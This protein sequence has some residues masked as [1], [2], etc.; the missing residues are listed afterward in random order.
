MGTRAVSAKRRS[1]GGH[2]PKDKG[3]LGAT[4]E[5]KQMLGKASGRIAAVSRALAD[6]SRELRALR[7]ALDPEEAA[8]LVEAVER[9]TEGGGQK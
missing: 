9:M 2:V 7:W 5:P 3:P 6:A 4:R 8:A 1:Q